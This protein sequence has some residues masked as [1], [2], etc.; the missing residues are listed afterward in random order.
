MTD[1]MRAALGDGGA[2][3]LA[4]LGTAVIWLYRSRWRVADDN[5]TE[6]G[7]NE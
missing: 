7:D 5:L 1:R 3:L 4:T 2:L 6:F